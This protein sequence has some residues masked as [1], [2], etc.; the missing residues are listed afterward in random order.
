[1]ALLSERLFFEKQPEMQ[2]RIG[3]FLAIKQ[4]VC[5]IGSASPLYYISSRSN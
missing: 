1:L 4:G 5:P 2:A 3:R